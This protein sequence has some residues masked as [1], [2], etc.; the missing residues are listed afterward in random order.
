M[1][2]PGG[3]HDGGGLGNDRFSCGERVP[4]SIA[5]APLDK[6]SIA[7]LLKTNDPI[8]RRTHATDRDRKSRLMT[9]QPEDRAYDDLCGYTL[10]RGDSSF[11]H[12]HVVDAFALQRADERSKP[13]GVAFALVGLYLHVERQWSGRR[14]QQAHMALARR[15]RVWPTFTLPADRGAITPSQVMDKPAGRERDEA[16]HMWCAS[17]WRA[18]KGH[19]QAVVDLLAEHG[20]HA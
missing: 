14:V 7:M 20:I 13:I 3:S 12:Q 2:A 10:S 15:K 16:I 4:M 19:R 18:F 11:I 6:T 8:G 5:P 9:M 1:C 17:V